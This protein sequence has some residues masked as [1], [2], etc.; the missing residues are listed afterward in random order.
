MLKR[1]LDPDV[2]TQQDAPSTRWVVEQC[3]SEDCS[4][5]R[6]YATK[7]AALRAAAKAAAKPRRLIT[8]VIVW[9]NTMVQETE[10]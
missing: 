4:H 5:L 6:D 7:A 3:E 2:T 10:V 8:K 9:K 1:P